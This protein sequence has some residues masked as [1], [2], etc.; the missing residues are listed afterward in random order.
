MR[1][2][3]M[4]HR[5][6]NR[7]GHPPACTCVACEKRRFFPAPREQRKPR[8]PYIGPGPTGKAHVCAV[9]QAIQWVVG[10]G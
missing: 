3:I 4:D 6:A 5:E 9:L 8:R 1:E 10:P 7:A 2:V